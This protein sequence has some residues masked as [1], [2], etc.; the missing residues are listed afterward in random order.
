[1]N[2]KT[3]YPAL[4]LLFLLSSFIT[5]AQ[6]PPAPTMQKIVTDIKADG[7]LEEL[8]RLGVPASQLA[9][10]K[11]E[12]PN[13]NDQKN[14]F[15]GANYYFENASTFRDRVSINVM[16]VIPK[17]T[18]NASYR[19]PITVI[20]QRFEPDGPGWKILN[21]WKYERHRTEIAWMVNPTDLKI[22]TNEEKKATI[23]AY[24]NATKLKEEYVNFGR[25]IIRV[26]KTGIY[27]KD[28]NFGIEQS[29]E[30]GKYIWNL[31]VETESIDEEND[32][33]IIET[34][35][36]V[37]QMSFKVALENGKYS[38]LDI[39]YINQD[40]TPEMENLAGITTS[41][42]TT[43]FETPLKV[44][45]WY[46]N[47]F[48]E[49][50]QKTAPFILVPCTKADLITQAKSVIDQ[51]LKLDYSTPNEINNLQLPLAEGA[52]IAEVYEKNRA[53]VMDA[54][55][56]SYPTAQ[57]VSLSHEEPSIDNNYRP[58]NPYASENKAAHGETEFYV[59]YKVEFDVPITK[60]QK[61]RRDDSNY[62]K[63]VIRWECRDGKMMIT[64]I[65]P[66]F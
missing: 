57:F 8:Q 56:T 48:T 33:G 18:F 19:V 43:K 61:E 59:R 35:Q 34:K 49:I 14:I 30:L 46:D 3:L 38:V 51:L 11:F 37:Y 45:N 66:N 6:N 12:E 5:F 55:K 23:E 39:A 26:A 41:Y 7:V 47:G 1:M 63:Y 13:A 60:K 29:Y 36:D 15:A 20:Y 4:V 25:K 24:L 28:Q 17:S 64:A 9:A 54:Y 16:A 58:A 40:V 65:E 2:K 27:N 21:N 22:P 32:E 44:G 50:Y 62:V 52:S 53:A 10:I 31:I 42:E